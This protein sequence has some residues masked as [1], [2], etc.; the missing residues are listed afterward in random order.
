MPIETWIHLAV[1]IATGLG[2]IVA[3]TWRL[4]KEMEKSLEPIRDQLSLLQKKL[5]EVELDVH[6]TFVR[7]DSFYELMNR[8][9]DAVTARIDKI[10]SKIDRMIEG[11]HG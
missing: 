9:Q 5:F 7:H 11:K 8:F 3:G 2:L 6:K 1:F 10:E 4:G